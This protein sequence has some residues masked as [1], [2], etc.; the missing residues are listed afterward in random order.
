V[1]TLRPCRSPRSRTQPCAGTGG[2]WPSSTRRCF[3]APRSGSR[4]RARRTPPRRSGAWPSV[5]L[6]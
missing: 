3:R 4:S 2:A 5:A 1:S 6:R